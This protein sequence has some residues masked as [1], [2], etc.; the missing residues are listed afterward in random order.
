M[1]N[2]IYKKNLFCIDRYNGKNVIVTANSNIVF[3]QWDKLV[4]ETI[5]P[6]KKQLISIYLWYEDNSNK[7]ERWWDFLD[8]L[9]AEDCQYFDKKQKEAIEKFKLFKKEFKKSFPDSVP[10]TSRYHI[11]DQ[12]Y[13]FYFYAEERY[14]FVEFIK[15]FRKILGWNFFIFQVWARDMIRMSPFTDDIVWCNGICLCCKSNRALPNIDIEVLLE[16][17]LEWRDIERLKWRCG[18]L[19]CSLVYE[20]ELYI[21]EN[22]KYP[23]KW[24]KIETKDCQTCWMVTSFNIMTW[25]VSVKTNDWDYIKLNLEEIKKWR[26]NQ[27]RIKKNTTNNI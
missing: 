24:T 13:Y 11:F 4:Y 9:S 3:K 17:H 26:E 23:S 7:I 2:K 1:E 12:Q 21:S 18:K 8:F 20:I 25:I 16:Q 15:K 27:A 6:Q 14:N 5:W 10:V 22:K 19:K